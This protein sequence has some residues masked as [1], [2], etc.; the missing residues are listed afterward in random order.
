MTGFESTFHMWVVFGLTGLLLALYVSRW[1]S[2]EISSLLVLTV[3]LVF[4]HLFPLPGTF[5]ANLLGAEKLL[6]GFANPALIAVLSLLVVGEGMVRTGTIEAIG[7]A[8]AQLRVKPTMLLAIILLLAG[9]LSAFLNNTPIVV[10]FIPILQALAQKTGLQTSRAMMALS[11]VAILG[12]MTTLIGSSTNLLVSSAMTQ[13]GL[14]ELGFLEMSGIGGLLALLGLAYVLFVLPLILPERNSISSDEAHGRQYISQ[15]VVPAD[16]DL[17]GAKAVAAAFRALPEITV[18]HIYRA[19]EIIFPP[20]DDYDVRPGDILV[21]AAHRKALTQLSSRQPGL[22]HPPLSYGLDLM[23][24]RVKHYDETRVEDGGEETAPVSSEHIMVEAMVTPTSRMIGLTLEQFGLQQNR[25]AIFVGI[26]RRG[27]MPAGRMTDIRLQSGDVLLLKDRQEQ[28]ESL[29]P[30][31]D[32]VLIS[33]T[34]GVV[35][36]RV[37]SRRA[38]TIFVTTIA[39]AA[40]DTIPIVMAAVG[41]ATAMIIAGCLNMRQAGRALDR[42]IFLLVGTSLAV[43]T[44]LTA[45]GGAAYIASAVVTMF[46]ET[47]VPIIL[48]AFFL[49]VAMF[50]NVLSNNAC[51]VLFTPIGIGLAAQVGVDPRLFALTV[52]FACN[53][54]FATPMGYQTNLLV[55]GPGR[56]QFTDFIK[57]GLP[58]QLLLWLAFSLI[59][60]AYWNL[61]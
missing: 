40:T 29:R 20:F 61:T 8:I 30:E 21:I 18:R 7:E 24:R 45:T 55:M 47:S 51:A 60:P 16:S 46:G 49:V 10:I 17:I 50:T 59:A 19:E 13:M 6:A 25:K 53:C 4:F 9:V 33:G 22:F 54:S 36:S 3:L 28:I 43:G 26:L 42:T 5:N 56:Y 57:A 12:G 52:L 32:L 2:L 38:L 44:A 39:L 15:F 11:F 35:P 23:G 27:Q 1:L 37:R 14:R 34:Y 48:S 31:R 41:A 58:L